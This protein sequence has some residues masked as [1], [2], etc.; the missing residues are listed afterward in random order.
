MVKM[1]SNAAVFNQNIS[2]WNVDNVLDEK[3]NGM[4]AGAAVM[5]EFGG[6]A[7]QGPPGTNAQEG[8]GDP[9]SWFQ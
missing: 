2:N 7:P 9:G 8:A 6:S 1:F 5:L 3:F 4:F